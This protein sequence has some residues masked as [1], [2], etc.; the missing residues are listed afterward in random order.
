MSAG[1]L[2]E[3][4]AQV[5]QPFLEHNF[6]LPFLAV[7]V[8]LNGSVLIVRYSTPWEPTVLGKHCG[9]DTFTFPVKVTVIDRNG[10]T[11]QVLVI[12]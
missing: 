10:A 8:G 9:D 1:S 6:K 12:R 2:T 5:L 4:L 11:E 7:A 3:K